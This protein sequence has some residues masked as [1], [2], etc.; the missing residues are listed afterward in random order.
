MD[1]KYLKQ[2]F[3]LDGVGA[4]VS[5]ILLGIVLVQLETY[6]GIPRETLY[7]LAALPCFFAVYDFYCYFS[8]EQHLGKYLRGIAIVNLLYCV[9]S[10]GLAFYHYQEILYLGWIYIIVEIMIVVALAMIE[11]KAAG[12]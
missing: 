1:K 10:L 4:I 5:A 6:F 3:L 12:N 11:L 7:L 2:L 9:L 8:V